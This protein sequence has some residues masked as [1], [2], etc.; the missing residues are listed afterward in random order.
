MD[1]IIHPLW[2]MDLYLHIGSGS[3]SS[4]VPVGFSSSGKTQ[5]RKGN[6]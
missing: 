6:E 3:S 5:K 1:A 4:I 2:H